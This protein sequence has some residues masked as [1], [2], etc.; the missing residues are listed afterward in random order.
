MVST[1]V[2]LVRAMLAEGI[3]LEPSRY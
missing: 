3:P 2:S 1:R